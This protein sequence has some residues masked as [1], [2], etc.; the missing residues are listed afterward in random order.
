MVRCKR[1]QA[2]KSLSRA[3]TFLQ[4]I[5]YQIRLHAHIFQ[6]ANAHIDGSKVTLSDIQNDKSK[7]FQPLK[8][9]WMNIQSGDYQCVFDGIVMMNAC[10]EAVMFLYGF[11]RP[12]L[13]GLWSRIEELTVSV[14]NTML[15]V[16]RS[17]GFP[18]IETGSHI[19]Y[20]VVLK[21]GEI[22]ENCL[23]YHRVEMS[24]FNGDGLDV[25]DMELLDLISALDEK[26][27]ILAN[28]YGGKLKLIL[29]GSDATFQK[30][31]NELLD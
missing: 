13:S 4:A 23:G 9:V 20:R 7:A 2:R 27:P 3:A 5:L 25:K 15:S 24:R 8:A 11:V 1:V 22:C 18:L 29:Q 31:K 28:A 10:T 19:I 17:D 16:E 12:I 30:A 6:F 26:I 21:S 14:H